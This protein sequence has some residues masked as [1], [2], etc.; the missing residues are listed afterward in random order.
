M[1]TG[2][3]SIN[4]GAPITCATAEILAN[5]AMCEGAH[6][7]VEHVVM[8]EFHFFSEPSRGRAWQLPLLCMPQTQ[9]L[10]MSA[11]LGDTSAFEQKIP[12]RSGRELTVVSSEE[13]P[14]PLQYEYSERP[15]HEALRE[16]LQQGRGPVYV[17]HF[18]Q[19]EASE[20]AQDLV[21]LSVADRP[22]R[23]AI[24]REIS[25]T[26]FDSV[27]GPELK[28]ILRSGVGVHHAGMLPRYRRLVERLAQAGLLQVVCG[29]DTLGVGINVPIPVPLGFYSFGGWK[30]S[31]FGAHSIYGPDGVHFYTRPKVITT[32]WSDPS[33]RGVDLGFP[34]NR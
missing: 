11:T 16:L 19:R 1:M 9:L 25:G 29:T 18:S 24:A 33:H 6:A 17:V 2:D 14:V 12:A 21:S 3:V 10:L 7:P 5:I 20:L 13:R 32:R 4:R 28:R 30:N 26:R 23:D 8:D 31:L 15:M 22:Q 27:F 34:R